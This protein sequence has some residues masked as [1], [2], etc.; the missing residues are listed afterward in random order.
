MFVLFA[1]GGRHRDHQ[2]VRDPAFAKVYRRFFPGRL[3][4]LTKL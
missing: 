3:P 1:M 4:F 2:P